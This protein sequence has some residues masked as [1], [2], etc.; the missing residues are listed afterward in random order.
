MKEPFSVLTEVNKILK[1]R[2]VD[3]TGE[4]PIIEISFAAFA[5]SHAMKCPCN[6]RKSCPC[7]DVIDIEGGWKDKCKC[8]LFV[9]KRKP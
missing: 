7:V 5:L 8:G 1:D 9:A 6:K 4:T 3:I 2:N